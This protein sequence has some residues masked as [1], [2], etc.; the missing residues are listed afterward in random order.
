MKVIVGGKYKEE[1][2]IPDDVITE[3]IEWYNSGEDVEEPANMALSQ[4]EIIV[5]EHGAID[6]WG[7]DGVWDDTLNKFF[8]AKYPHMDIMIIPKYVARYMA[9]SLTNSREDDSYFEIFTFVVNDRTY[10]IYHIT[11][12]TDDGDR[13]SYHETRLL[14]TLEDMSGTKKY[15]DFVGCEECVFFGKGYTTDGVYIFP[16]ESK[17]PFGQDKICEMCYDTRKDLVS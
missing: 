11:E 5:G 15:P 7:I 1:V 3:Y 16:A 14:Y 6:E 17:K 4:K 12:L 2:E 9:L 13:I 8:E 10:S